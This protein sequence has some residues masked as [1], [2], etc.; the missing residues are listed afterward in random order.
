MS[1]RPM[2]SSGYGYQWWVES[3]GPKKYTLNW[4]TASNTGFDHMYH[5]KEAAA[6]C[7]RFESSL[8]NALQWLAVPPAPQMSCPLSS[9]PILP[10]GKT[11]TVAAAVF[12]K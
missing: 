12:E 8:L 5:T 11:S 7:V 1:A 9:M 6:G 3:D 4:S 2:A 10:S